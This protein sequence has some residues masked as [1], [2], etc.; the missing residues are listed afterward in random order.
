MNRCQVDTWIERL[1][2][3]VLPPQCLL[4]HGRGQPPGFDLCRP[5]EDELPTLMAP[6][7]RCGLPREHFAA[8]GNAA[9]CSRC[10]DAPLGFSRCFAPFI[11]GAHVDGI[12]HAL[13]YEGALA[14]ARVLGVLLGRAVVRAG[15][16]RQVDVLVPMPLHSS[17]LVERGFNQSFEIARFTARIVGQPCAPRALLRGRAT[18]PQVEL[19][20]LERERNVSGAFTAATAHSS[21]VRNQRV[22]LIDD[23]VTTGSTA[24]EAARTL[25]AMGASS[26]DVWSVARALAG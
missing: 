12:I 18:K 8:A 21:A 2:G 19:S 10:R 15:L 7:P 9:D 24:G 23:V 13:K 1:A 20:R 22:A 4:C 25:F 6:C 14:N 3:W 16:H 26:V 17:R 5:C 11:Y